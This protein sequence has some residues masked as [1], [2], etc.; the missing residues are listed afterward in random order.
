MPFS[1]YAD[2]IS[3]TVTITV[4]ERP[5]TNQILVQWSAQEDGSGLRGY[6]VEVK[7]DDGDAAPGVPLRGEKRRDLLRAV[8]FTRT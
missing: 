8:V 6:D 1:V 5:T 3:P 7:V 4:P 2:H